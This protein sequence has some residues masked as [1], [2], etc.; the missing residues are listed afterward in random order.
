M[1]ASSLRQL[2]PSVTAAQGEDTLI[3]AAVLPR[4]R[5]RMFTIEYQPGV[6]G[7]LVVL[8][9]DAEAT[10]V[11]GTTVL[12]GGVLRQARPG[13]AEEHAGPGTR[14]TIRT[15]QTPGGAAV[16][17]ATSLRTAAGRQLVTRASPSQVDDA[18]SPPAIARRRHAHAMRTRL[19]P[20]RSRS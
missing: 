9:P 12:A 17:F 10:P 2:T 14:S 8:A 13:E 4:A 3:R 15:R 16:L 20:G 5:P 6:D 18:A 19:H 7:E 1:F 11:P